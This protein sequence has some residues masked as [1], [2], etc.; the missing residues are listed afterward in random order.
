MIRQVLL[1]LINRNGKSHYC[2]K[3]YSVT[4]KRFYFSIEF[5]EMLNGQNIL[6]QMTPFVSSEMFRD[7]KFRKSP[8]FLVLML[9][10]STEL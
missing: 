4:M 3:K 10:D 6:Y 9:S 5:G 1:R 2:M 8:P 7:V